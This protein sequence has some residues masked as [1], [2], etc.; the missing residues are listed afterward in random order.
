MNQKIKLPVNTQP[1]DELNKKII[2]KYGFMPYEFLSEYQ[3]AM[4]PI[5]IKCK[6]CGKIRIAN[7]A[8]YLRTYDVPCD[9]Y[10]L[11]KIELLKQAMEKNI[12]NF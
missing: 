12:M 7:R 2:D 3:G 5:K 9:C 11:L 4:K 1:Q 10:R 8:N 6:K